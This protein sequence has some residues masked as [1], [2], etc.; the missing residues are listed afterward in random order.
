[1]VTRLSIPLQL[2][3]LLTSGQ[4]FVVPRPS[5]TTSQLATPLSY[6][7]SRGSNGENELARD[8]PSTKDWR[9]FRAKLVL[10]EYGIATATEEQHQQWAYQQDLLE[11][12]ALLVH[13]GFDM[14]KPHLTKAVL[15]V[16]ETNEQETTALILNRPANFTL[17]EK[18]FTAIL[19][20]GGPHSSFHTGEEQRVYCIHRQSNC[21][22]VGQEILSGL[23]LTSLEDAKRLQA[24][25][26]ASAADFLYISG[27]EKLDTAVVTAGIKSGIWKSI[28]ADA[29]T[30]QQHLLPDMW[31]N[32]LTLTGTPPPQV[33]GCD[34]DLDQ[35]QQIQDQLLLEWSR[36]TLFHGPPPPPVTT[37]AH[38]IKEGDL[39]RASSLPHAFLFDHQEF[40]KSLLLILEANEEY[41]VG[42]LLTLP[43]TEHDPLTDLTVRH[44]GSDSEDVY[45]LHYLGGDVIGGGRKVG[46]S[47]S[48]CSLEEAKA[49]LDRGTVERDE[50]LVIRGKVMFP[51]VN[52]ALEWV[53]PD[54][55]PDVWS[56]LNEQQ[57]LGPMSLDANVDVA[58]Q[59]WRMAGGVDGDNVNLFHLGYEAVKQWLSCHFLEADEDEG[60]LGGLK[61]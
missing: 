19:L 7:N 46:S 18:E 31:T 15:M 29:L 45:C 55:A 56:L 52:A 51:K 44:G 39:L 1:M 49:A 34:N 23:F 42:A 47:F 41:A 57:A 9:E 22:E 58:C 28:T 37:P 53:S 43:T 13:Q 14:S 16:V 2:A 38:D 30:L 17:N 20:Y 32:L 8:S 5:F 36:T 21:K 25:G 33:S 60:M 59:A 26:R 50:L 35:Q 48:M 10:Q 12:G 27:Y 40:H 61:P 6:Y 54:L 4:A 3:L 24:E 11:I